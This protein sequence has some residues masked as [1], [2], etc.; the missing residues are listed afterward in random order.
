MISLQQT[1]GF[2]FTVDGGALVSVLSKVNSIASA[3]KASDAERV[4]LM[5]ASDKKLFALSYTPDTF[6]YMRVEAKVKGEGYFQ[7]DY[8]TLVRTLK[9]RKELEVKVG[10]QLEVKAGR[11]AVKLNVSEIPGNFLTAIEN[12]LKVAKADK[13]KSS[14]MQKIRSAI[15]QVDIQDIYAGKKNN[16]YLVINEGKLIAS[17]YDS[18]HMVILRDKVT[19]R[20]TKV[21]FHSATFRLLD[22]FIGESDVSLYVGR[23]LRVESEDFVV[24]LPPVQAEDA[25]YEIVQNYIKGLEDPVAS[26]ELNNAAIKALHNI[27]GIISGDDKMDIAVTDGKVEI[28]IKSQKGSIS[29]SYKCKTTGEYSFTVDPRLFLDMYRKVTLPAVVNLHGSARGT[30][31]IF[32]I[33]QDNIRMAG[34]YYES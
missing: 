2:S 18:F 7:F 30:S 25:Q 4:F 5:F 21:A 32:S 9:G 28:S 33:K 31:N 19:Y 23:H 12:Y 11:Y 29:D 1:D 6:C 34:S 17:S 16:C 27:S 26:F 15:K 20:D 10:K 24:C 13:M 8:E 14:D 22:K 3:T